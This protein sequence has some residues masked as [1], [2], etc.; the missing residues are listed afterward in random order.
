M[1]TKLDYVMAPAT[2]VIGQRI[3]DKLSE[4]DRAGFE[5]ALARQP[6]ADSADPLRAGHRNPDHR[7]VPGRDRFALPALGRG[8]WAPLMPVIPL[9]GIYSGL[10]SPTEAAVTL[11]Y[12]VFVEIAMHME[13]TLRDLG[14]V[15]LETAKPGGALFPLIAITL[16]LNLIPIENRVPGRILALVEGWISG[17][18]TFILLVTLA[19]VL[20]SWLPGIPLLI[21]QTGD[22]THDHHTA[23]LPA[24]SARNRGPPRKARAVMAEQGL[25]ALVPFNPDNIC[26]LINLANTV[27]ARPLIPVPPAEGTPLFVMPRLEGSHIRTRSVGALEFAPYFEFPAPKGEG[28]TVALAKPLAGRARPGIEFDCPQ[29]AIA[30]PADHP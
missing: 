18:V 16:S 21:V 11:I 10:F 5:R 7:P 3:W 17:P 24:R 20:I 29:F 30:T 9:G 28:W 2:I 14:G 27:H 22:H 12:A 15:G 19:L 25:D 1:L 23:V 26:Y 13:L 8:G 6:A 4:G